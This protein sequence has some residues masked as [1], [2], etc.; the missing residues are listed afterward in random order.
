MADSNCFIH[1]TTLRSIG[2]CL[3]A[4]LSLLQPPCAHCANTPSPADRAP[5]Q[6]VQSMVM[7]MADEYIAALGEAMY[8]V[9]NSGKLDAKGRWLTMS[10]L[11]NG[12]GSSLDIAIGPNPSV[13]LLDFLVLTSLQTWAFESHW[14]PAGIGEAGRPAVARLK[15]ADAAAW[16]NAR[17]SLSEE[18]LN[19]L[20]TLINAWIA[21]NPD[22]TVVALVRFN[23]FADERKISSLS[24]RGQAHG[25]LSSVSE[26]SA[27]VDDVRLLGERLLWFAG[28][29]PYLLGEQSELTVYRMLDKPE[30]RQ[31]VEASR[32]A[33]ELTDTLAKRIAAIDTDLEK[34][35]EQLFKQLADERT[36]AI[37]QFGKSMDDTVD[38]GFQRLAKER[39]ELLHNLAVQEKEAVVVMGDMRKTLAASDS[40]AKEIAA[41]TREADKLLARFQTILKE[42]KDPATVEDYRQTVI[43]TGTSAEKLTHMLERLNAVLDSPSLDRTIAAMNTP[44]DRLVDRLFWRIALLICLLIGG[45]A[46][47]RS[48][49]KRAGADNK[50]R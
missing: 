26:A 36:A 7:G 19:T 9:T 16:S 5:Q 21:E 31:L 27:A 29:Y 20:R 44:I 45:F 10:F 48:R 2:I 38:K 50:D 12:V 49:S 28:R 47:L 3:V 6:K 32:S 13:N 17:K 33:K 14:I 35:R 30:I 1:R 46:L 4:V 25:L 15:Q 23:D 11:R 18:Q 34:Q 43:E 8:L 41:A 42:S 24:L 39:K 37:D 40:T 22:R